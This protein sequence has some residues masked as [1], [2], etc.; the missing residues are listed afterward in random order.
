V[1]SPEATAPE[2]TIRPPSRWGDFGLRE[3]ARYGELLYFV[4]KREIQ[5]RYKQSVVGIAWA[6]LQPLTYAFVFA[7]FFGRL[8]KV[9]SQG[10]PYPVW[11]IAALVPWIFAYQSVSQAAMS[12]IMDQNLVTKVYFPRLVAPLARVLSFLVDLA[13][14][15]GILIVFVFA[16]GQHPSIGLVAMPAFI[17][18]A[19]VLVVGAGSLLAAINAKYRDVTLAVPLITQLWLFATPIAYPASLIKGT[20]AYIYAINPM[21]SVIEGSRWA[22]LGTPAPPIGT[23]AVSTASALLIATG[24]LIY[25]RRTERFLADVI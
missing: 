2:I 21:V 18:L 8:A 6:V 15:L 20:W 22:F 14:A 12:L 11:A 13:I 1:T 10:I 25:F 3:L 24:G 4:T 7:L 16:Y 23:L 5:I 9:P 17:L 19:F